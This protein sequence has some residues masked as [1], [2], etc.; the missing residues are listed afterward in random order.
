M[1]RPPNDPRSRWANM[2]LA[3]LF[4]GGVIDVIKTKFMARGR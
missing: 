3:P 4:G 2:R 1:N